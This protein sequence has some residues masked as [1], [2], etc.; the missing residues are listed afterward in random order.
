[1]KIGI[2]GGAFDPVHCGHTDIAEY[3]LKNTDIGKI[4]F[5][6]LGDAPYK[7]SVTDKELRIKMLEE[8]LKELP[9]CFVSRIEADR[10]GKTYTFDT[11]SRLQT[12]TDDEYVYIIGADKLA[13]LD[14]WYHAEDI[15]SLVTFEVIARKGTD[16]HK[17][18]QKLIGMGA[19]LSFSDY[20]GKDIS[21]TLI[22]ER[23]R[24]N[25]RITGLVAPEVEKII[26]EYGLYKNQ[27]I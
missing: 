26:Y 21:S 18:A 5:L 16:A 4:M 2:L 25:D 6:P 1:M 27:R 24:K 20:A 14:K 15:F 13:T 12:D 9:D 10:V 11:L 3:C 23:V 22:R 8:A 17:Y 19:R 7:T